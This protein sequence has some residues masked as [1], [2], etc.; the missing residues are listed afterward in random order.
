M[1]DT[2]PAVFDELVRQTLDVVVFDEAETTPSY[3]KLL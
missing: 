3:V 2:P 1:N